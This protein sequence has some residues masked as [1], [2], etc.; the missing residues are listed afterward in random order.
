MTS[1]NSSCSSLKNPILFNS[2]YSKC[3]NLSLVS[4][5][6]KTSAPKPNNGRKTSIMAFCKSLC[7]PYDKSIR[8]PP[9]S[10]TG[11][12]MRLRRFSIS[13]LSDLISLKKLDNSSSHCNVPKECNNA[14]NDLLKP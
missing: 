3:K 5:T 12:F 2:S 4:P 9:G 8:F 10:V 14:A 6:Y 11:T 7:S 1:G 13:S